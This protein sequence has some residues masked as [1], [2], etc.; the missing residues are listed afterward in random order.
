MAQLM[1]AIVW[2]IP[3]N[4]FTGIFLPEVSHLPAPAARVQLESGLRV[5][6]DLQAV[7]MDLGEA[8]LT[9]WEEL[10]NTG[11]MRTLH[12]TKTQV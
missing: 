3:N 4:V 8:H 7:T 5:T 9:G 6:S 1:P 12:V 11:P 2:A 10:K